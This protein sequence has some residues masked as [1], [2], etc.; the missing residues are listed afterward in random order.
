VQAVQV[1]NLKLRA[2]LA[3]LSKAKELMDRDVSERKETEAKRERDIRDRKEKEEREERIRKVR[4][5]ESLRE[6]RERERER[7][8]SVGEPASLKVNK[9]FTSAPC[10]PVS[11][12]SRAICEIEGKS[13]LAP[14]ARSVI[15]CLILSYP[16]VAWHIILHTIHCCAEHAQPIPPRSLYMMYYPSLL[17]LYNRYSRTRSQSVSPASRTEGCALYPPGSGG[18]VDAPRSTVIGALQP[19]V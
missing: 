7:D 12:V 17:Y 2:E 10:S 3:E 13:P 16:R 15:C 18:G 8:R 6:I 19:I 11:F 1:E 4:R 5:E 14:A 9:L